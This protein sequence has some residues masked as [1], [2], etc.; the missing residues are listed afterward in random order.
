MVILRRAHHKYQHIFQREIR[1]QEVG[2]EVGK[3][4][5][6]KRRDGG[7]VRSEGERE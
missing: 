7:E 1:G 5:E 3:R 4:G 2:G 6:V